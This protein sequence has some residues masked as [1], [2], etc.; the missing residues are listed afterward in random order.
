MVKLNSLQ[1]IEEYIKSNDISF[2][3]FGNETCGV[4]TALLPKIIEILKRYPNI[5]MAYIEIDDVKLAME[6]YSIF[7]IPVIL[8]YV[9]GKETIREARFISV[10]DVEE[11]LKRISTIYK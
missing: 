6:R 2:L 4:C 1:E 10:N 7:T 3:Y 8:L 9:E 11:K 5:K